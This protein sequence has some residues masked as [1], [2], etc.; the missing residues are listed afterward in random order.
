M[1]KTQKHKC[2]SKGEWIIHMKEYYTADTMNETDS[3]LS[4]QIDFKN[5]SNKKQFTI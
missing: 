3:H 5:E 2:I 4:T 1:E